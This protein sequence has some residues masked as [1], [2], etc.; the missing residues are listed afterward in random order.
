MKIILDHLSDPHAKV[1]KAVLDCLL[2]LASNYPQPLVPYLDRILPPLLVR[3]SGNK[4]EPRIQSSA[5]LSA[6]LTPLRGSILLTSVLRILDVLPPKPRSAALEYMLH[7]I[8]HSQEHL[9]YPPHMRSMVYKIL[10]AMGVVNVGGGAVGGG[11]ASTNLVLTLT[12]PTKVGPIPPELRRAGLQCL[13]ELYTHYRPQFLA[14]VLP[15]PVGV[16][17]EVKKLLA[18]CHVNVDADLATMTKTAAFSA[19]TAPPSNTPSVLTNSS[20]PPP[21]NTNGPSRIARPPSVKYVIFTSFHLSLILRYSST[22]SEK[23]LRDET[24][25]ELRPDKVCGFAI[26]SLSV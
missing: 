13:V 1:V 14:Q 4:D 22:E 10:V 12:D 17:F 6:L 15:M 25:T 2:A 9:T 23:S 16:L 20:F 11:S 8:A 21:S 26:F 5:V 19:S 7:L 18:S 24:N 3:L